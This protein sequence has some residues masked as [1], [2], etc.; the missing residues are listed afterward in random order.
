MLSTLLTCLFQ[1]FTPEKI[2]KSPRVDFSDSSGGNRQPSRS[3]F[4]SLFIS[5]LL[6]EQRWVVRRKGAQSKV[7]I[8]LISHSGS[9]SRAGSS[10]SR[11]CCFSFSLF[12]THPPTLHN[13]FKKLMKLFQL[14][15]KLQDSMKTADTSIYSSFKW[16]K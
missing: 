13:L 4:R 5:F 7:V 12:F 14:S 9:G 6:L 15:L 8:H 10:G 1:P 2:D 3:A 11:C 16:K